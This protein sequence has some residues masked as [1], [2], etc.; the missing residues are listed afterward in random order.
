[1]Y[2][3]LWFYFDLLLH[4]HT[5]WMPAIYHLPSW[6]HAHGLLPGDCV[7]L[8]IC[9]EIFFLVS[10]L[11]LGGKCLICPYSTCQA[12]LLPHHLLI[13]TSQ[14]YLS[15]SGLLAWQ[16]FQLPSLLGTISLPDTSSPKPFLI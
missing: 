13:G 7:F 8:L 12:C 2:F 1:M 5:Q 4:L 10:A 15:C 16:G 3:T 9:W 14:T 11:Q 6:I